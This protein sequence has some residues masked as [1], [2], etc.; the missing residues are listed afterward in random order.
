MK[1]FID[2]NPYKEFTPFFESSLL[3]GF[4]WNSGVLALYFTDGKTYIYIGVPR[5]VVEELNSAESKGQYFVRNIK[6]K[7]EYLHV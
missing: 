4:L 1:T 7:Y 6:G 2:S 3:N 5:G